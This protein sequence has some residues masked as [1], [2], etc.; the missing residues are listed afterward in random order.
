MTLVSQNFED[1]FFIIP[2]DIYCAFD[3]VKTGVS[4]LKGYQRRFMKKSQILKQNLLME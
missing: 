1:L 2:L 4:W 3:I